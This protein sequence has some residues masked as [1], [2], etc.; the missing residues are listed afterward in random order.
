MK[1]E[2]KSIIK[3][4]QCYKINDVDDIAQGTDDAS[5]DINPFDGVAAEQFGDTFDGLDINTSSSIKIVNMKNQGQEEEISGLGS[6]NHG[7]K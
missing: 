3:L 1:G 2:N 7:T 5:I 4:N 6:S